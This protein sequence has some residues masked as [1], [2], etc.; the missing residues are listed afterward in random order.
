MDISFTNEV[1]NE[2][3]NQQRLCFI[4]HK[5]LTDNLEGKEIFLN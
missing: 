4:M 5:R 2:S 1:V 3:L